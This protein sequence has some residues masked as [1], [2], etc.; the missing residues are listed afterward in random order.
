MCPSPARLG[1]LMEDVRLE[2]VDPVQGASPLPP[3]ANQPVPEDANELTVRYHRLFAAKLQD[4]WQ[5][6]RQ[7]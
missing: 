6:L 7:D 3:T 2:W 5:K 4:W 1:E